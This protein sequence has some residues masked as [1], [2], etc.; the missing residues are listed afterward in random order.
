MTKCGEIANIQ[1]I[2]RMSQVAVTVNLV[3]QLTRFGT[4]T[5]LL[6]DRLLWSLGALACLVWECTWASGTYMVVG[7]SIGEDAVAF[8]P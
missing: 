7:A 1:Q 3:L 5:L 8:V 4:R 2:G 6:E